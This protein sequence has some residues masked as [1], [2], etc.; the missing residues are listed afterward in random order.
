[1]SGYQVDDATLEEIQAERAAYAPI[2]VATRQLADLSI[3]TQVSPE[4]AARALEHIESA[5][6][7]LGKDVDD[8]SYGVRH[9]RIGVTRA[10]GNA[11]VGLRNPVA[12]P[13]A[14]VRD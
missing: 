5:I 11:V 12:P 2:A 13:L 4:D 8:D 9:S 10:W 7:L 6:A 3:R 1:M 14:I